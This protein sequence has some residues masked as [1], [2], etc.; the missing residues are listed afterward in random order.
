LREFLV[1][2]C[3]GE[4]KI[5]AIQIEITLFGKRREKMVNKETFP[6]SGRAVNSGVTSF[7]WSF[8]FK[9]RELFKLLLVENIKH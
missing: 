3:G 6:T 7:Q 4:S 9:Y 1:D 8:S 2:R 5:I